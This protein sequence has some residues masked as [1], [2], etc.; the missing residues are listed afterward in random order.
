MSGSGQAGAPGAGP[1]L[2]LIIRQDQTINGIPTFNDFNSSGEIVLDP[3]Q[4][5][6]LF[7]HN[8][9]TFNAVTGR[10]VFL[11]LNDRDGDE[12]QALAESGLRLL[13]G[14]SDAETAFWDPVIVTDEAGKATVTIKLPERSTAWKLRSKGIDGASLSGQT[15][16]ELVTKKDLFGELKLP[17]AFTA[18]DKARVLVEVHNS[19][20][21]ARKIA[22][23]LK[24]T[25]GEKATEI[26][27]TLDVQ[28][29]G[30][31]E[32]S[33]PVEITGG[34]S[35]GFELTVSGGDDHSDRVART[36]A[37]HPHGL[38]VYATAGG[39]AAQ[40]T[41]ALVQFDKDLPARD[42]VLE[43]LVGPNVN[44][45]LFDAV[46]GGGFYPVE[47]C[48]LPVSG[49]E[50][51]VSD[52]LGG[53]ALLKMIGASR[54]TGTPEAQALAGRVQSALSQL[55][56]S[57]RDDGAWTWS[58]RPD[59]GEPDSFL[60]SRAVWALASARKAG[61]AVQSEQFQKAVQYLQTAFTQISQT[62]REG[63][64]V[65]LH[66]LSAAGA[67]DFAAANR[68]HRERNNLSASGLLHV[69]LA[70][71]ELDRN[72][73]AAELVRLVPGGENREPGGA[74]RKAIASGLI[75]WMRDGT[76]LDALHLLALE[77]VDPANAKAAE[78]ANKLMA[79]RVGARWPIEKA[80]GPA[81]A[82]LAQWFART[83][84]V[85][86]KYTLTV[87]V[88]DREV[89]K[90]TVEPSQ[91]ASRRIAMPADL[92]VADK[93]QRINFDLEGR[94]T[95]TYSAVLTGF[96]P[97]EQLKSTSR[98][99]AVGRRYEPAQQMLD[100]QPI[101]RGFSV[102]TGSYQAFANPLT[103]LPVGERGEVTLLPR[104]LNVRNT[105]DEQ[106]D[107]LVVTE[108]VPAGCTVL[109][110]SIKGDFERY[111]MEPGAITFYIGDKRSPG[112]IQYTLVGYLPGEYR[113][114]PTV[115]RSFY[116]PQRIAVAEGKS[117]AVLDRGERSADE[118]RLSPDE[119]Y[120]LGKRLL[121]KGDHAAAH[122]HLTDLF[123]N[124]RTND[125]TYKDTVQ[126][127]FATSLAATSHGEIVKYFE[128]IKERFADVQVSFED[129]LKVAAAYR[130]LGEYER[131]YL[132]YRSTVQGSFERESQVAGFLDGR[133]EFLRSVQ[134]MER[135]LRDYPGEGY[136]AA[137]TY[138]LAQEVYRKAP[139]AKDAKLKTANVTRV[140]LIHCAIQM[141]DH[142]IS[143]WPNDP[144][145]DQASFALANALLDLDQYEPA[146]ARCE[147]FAERYPQSRLIDSYWYIMAYSHFA[148][149]RHEQALELSRKVAE[150][151]FAV[152][153]T[154]GQRDADN[155]W[156]AVYIMGQI[157]H[158]LGQAAEAIAEY[159]R[160]KDRFAD[161]A[162][163]ITFFTRKAIGFEEVT[164]IKPADAKQVVLKF[165]NVPEA[166]IKVY[167]IDLMKFGLMQRNLDRI[168]AINLAGIRPYH[169]ETVKLG[170]GK[171]YKDREHTLT[172]PLREEGAYLVVCRG[173][174]LY[175]SGL[176]VVSP[177]ALEVQ[178]DAVSG[179]V[180]V[181]V[182]EVTLD[183]YADDVHVKVIGSANDDFRTG[184][185]DLRG[186]FIADNVKG[187]STVIAMVDENRYAFYRG[188]TPLQPAPAAPMEPAAAKGEAAPQ[189]GQDM[190]R[191]NLYEMNFDFQNSNSIQYQNLLRNERSGVQAKEAY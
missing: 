59:A 133:G 46:L 86:E 4:A 15:E 147:K 60:T 180:R 182:K 6:R 142:F 33:F 120:H 158:S 13:P 165:R 135:L 137:A 102:L 91:D 75:P 69:A 103:Q 81:V 14:M 110:D 177:L 175:A 7:K 28:G 183:K 140:D 92:L 176:V 172:L 63:Q 184:D 139:L 127:L 108:P 178:E 45:A 19:L 80:N 96:V 27:R 114:T 11:S 98:D 118:Y 62:D 49:I 186:L 191:Q 157:Y 156:E 115:V 149:G 161:A 159:T 138:A 136:V 122:G 111:E 87:Y 123:A 90:F 38:P 44:R 53:V 155:K 82:A 187:T 145:D 166:S 55:I 162:E 3:Q 168:T 47:R 99:W 39:S 89:D 84:H 146:I 16:V 188:K 34:D 50:R 169:E 8:V 124:W 77:S 79:T 74:A 54:D 25:L 76:E 65:L 42:P 125:A 64:A 58:G 2:S 67:A 105:P 71:V 94:G 154:G 129:I 167:R 57:Q 5:A 29:P 43:I 109:G 134:V 160:V 66:G 56:S 128:I 152:P 12:L 143:T 170:D 148:L 171:D 24:S 31:S 32:V 61:F 173:E 17:L 190:L 30:I 51:S 107:Y 141:L 185:T 181:T 132:V 164:T 95:F 26:T 131:S 10:G 144:A 48:F 126:M 100:G 85:P 52:V 9:H 117:L 113:A 174:N 21:G 70:L 36:V 106:Y 1:T 78:L 93:P 151:R 112:N 83:K 97:A 18:G 121:A 104:R 68:L 101:P 41:I 35:A 179:R 116:E 73:M 119:L 20:E 22:V 72:E 150:A 189:P 130:E 153:E 163:A 40:S 37:V 23:T 88:N